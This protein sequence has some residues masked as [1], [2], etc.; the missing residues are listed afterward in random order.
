MSIFR[1]KTAAIPIASTVTIRVESLAVRVGGTVTLQ[2]PLAPISKTLRTK[3]M[4][5]TDTRVAN[6]VRRYLPLVW[7]VLRRAGLRTI[8]ADDASQDVFWVFAQ[9]AAEVDEA[10]ERSFLVSTALRVASERRR[11]KWFRSVTEALDPEQLPLQTESPDKALELRRRFEILDEALEQMDVKER[12]VLV[13]AAFEEM[14]KPEIA[15]VLCIPEGT[16]ASRL[17]RAKASFEVAVH[18]LHTIK[19]RLL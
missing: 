1:S 15:A 4:A 2:V 11:S 10:A 19:G 16:V 8:D 12:E 5:N 17:H 18:R 7:R 6:V 14:T 9:R 3:S 13:L